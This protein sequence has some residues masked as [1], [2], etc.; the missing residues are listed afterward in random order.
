MPVERL[1]FIDESAARTDLARTHGRC[2]AGERLVE[3]L[4]AGHW[5]TSTMIAAVGVGGIRAPLLLDGP[6]DAESFTAYAEQS[7]APAL[8]AGDIVVLDNL[9]AHRDPRVRAAVES[10]GAT[11]EFLPPY[12][13]DF[14][15]I[16][17]AWSKVKAL[18]RKAAA[19]T[20]EDLL[21]AMGRA[22]SA[23]T[24]EDCHGFFRHCGY[25]ATRNPK[26]V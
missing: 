22:V 6:V 20:F 3:A 23:V 2:P 1:V 12:S 15:P 25:A 10:A 18:L 17:P 26:M 5:H 9:A 21:A 16:E 19:R 11:L 8:R 4:P 24:P 13:P 7:L 14:N